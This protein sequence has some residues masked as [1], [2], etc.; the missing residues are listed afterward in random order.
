MRVRRLGRLFATEQG[1]DWMVSHAAYPS[2]IRLN[3]KTIRIFF[4]SRDRSNR[5]C[6][7]WLDVDA[8]DPLK[9]K[10]IAERPALLPGAVGTFDE[11]GIAIGSIVHIN[12][13]LWL[14]FMGWAYSPSKIVRN[15]I[16]LAVSE[17]DG[18]TFKRIV[19]RPVLSRN[20]LDPYSLSY[21]Y[22][23]NPVDGWQMLYGSHRGAGKTQE[24]MRHSITYAT[25]TD[26]LNWQPTG[27]DLVK[28]QE[29]EFALTRPWL[30]AHS[31]SDFMLFSI[32][33][34]RYTIGLA[35]RV[36][37]FQWKRVSADLFGASNFEWDNEATCYASHIRVRQHDLI[38]YCGNGYGRTGFGIAEIE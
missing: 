2:P 9:I 27:R 10:A 36:G 4:V 28:L 25:S 14:Y 1:P 8:S 23:G 29:G 34:E 7:A 35:Q 11:G 21:P 15:E 6:V 3:Q 24:D 26:G 16:G 31:G 22:V 30:F 32:R 5:G 17:D 19:D 12:N 37:G 38:F 18:Q 33:R 13:A 20:P